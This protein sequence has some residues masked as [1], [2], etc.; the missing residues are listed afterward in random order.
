MEVTIVNFL[1][2]KLLPVI[3]LLLLCNQDAYA[4]LDPGT[5]SYIFQLLTATFL[6]AVFAI[7]VYWQKIV[8]LFKKSST[9]FQDDADKPK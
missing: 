6:G 4:Y 9:K 8:Q 5:G 7:K 1:S 3:L 2:G